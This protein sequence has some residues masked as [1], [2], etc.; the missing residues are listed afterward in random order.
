[1]RFVALSS[2]AG[3]GG[4][5]HEL[6]E[7]ISLPNANDRLLRGR[8]LLKAAERPALIRRLIANESGITAVEY[9]VLAC[10]IALVIV[11]FASSGMSLTALYRSVGLLAGALI[12]EDPEQI[13]VDPR[14]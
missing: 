12:G 1:V 3:L 5:A 11:S 8:S 13:P 14:Y 2:Q 9:G 7:S 10:V 6:D 4:L